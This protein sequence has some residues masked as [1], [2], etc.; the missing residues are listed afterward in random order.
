MGMNKVIIMGRLVRDP[1]IRTAQSGTTFAKFVVAVEREGKIRAGAERETDFVDVTAFKHTAEFV[2]K[3]FGKGDMIAVDGR[4]QS[5]KWTDKDGN[6]KIS[7]GVIASNVY[8]CG[9]VK[10]GEAKP[11]NDDI[12]RIRE[13]ARARSQEYAQA[14]YREVIV[15]DEEGLPF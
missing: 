4:L 3:Y 13:K 10:T 1:E 9:D 2:G 14:Q 7:W 5:N 12:E 6:S 11:V 8:F 15:D